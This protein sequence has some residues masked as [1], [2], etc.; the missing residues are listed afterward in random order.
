MYRIDYD[1]NTEDQKTAKK[2]VSFKNDNGVCKAHPK[3]YY[4]HTDNPDS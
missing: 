2:D 1:E 4:Y 3:T